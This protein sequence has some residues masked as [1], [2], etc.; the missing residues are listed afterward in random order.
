[1][2]VRVTTT[3]YDT[4]LALFDKIAEYAVEGQ[5]LEG[6]QVAYAWPGSDVALECIYGGG[7]RFDHEDAVADHPGILV[8]EIANISLYIRVVQRPP[9]P[10][11][12]AD[13]R[14]AAIG[15]VIGSIM[16]ANPTLAGGGTWLGIRSGQG[17]YSQTGEETVSV[18]AYQMRVA[19]NIA[20]GGG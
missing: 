4:K 8:R 7:I 10:V 20:Y 6:V 14:T 17:D 16:R 12:D 11:E 3:A 15:A 13:N 18:L 1:M 2:G 9:G 19:R 5:P